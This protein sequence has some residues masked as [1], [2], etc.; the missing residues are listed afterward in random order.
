MNFEAS[1]DHLNQLVGMVAWGVVAGAGTGSMVSLQFGE[2]YLRAKPVKNPT[3]DPIIR[4]YEGKWSLFIRDAAWRLD[5]E[6]KVLCSSRSNNQ[7]G[8]E[9]LQGLHQITNALVSDVRLSKPG[10]DLL[11]TFSNGL[12]LTVFCDC[13]NEDEGDNYWVFA[14]SFIFTVK[15]KGELAVENSR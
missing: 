15:P 4:E 8:A 1:Q 11:L 5:S 9:M 7:A 12:E 3:L 14:P 2:K 6:E 10:G 13:M